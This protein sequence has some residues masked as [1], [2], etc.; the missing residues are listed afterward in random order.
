MMIDEMIDKLT[1][2]HKDA[3]IF[4]VCA[5]SFSTHPHVSME[6][7]L[8]SR[9]A[10][11]A[12]ILRVCFTHAFLSYNAKTLVNESVLRCVDPQK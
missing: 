7:T 1:M 4:P 12:L 2:V 6:S 10:S 9:R 5:P 3:V 11:L 8:W